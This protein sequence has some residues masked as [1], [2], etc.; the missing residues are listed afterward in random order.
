M[1]YLKSLSNVGHQGMLHRAA[2]FE[3][4]QNRVGVYWCALKNLVS[5]GIR[6]GVQD[7]TTTTCNR[8]LTHTASTHRR[9][10]VRNV[11]RRPLHVDGYI[12]NRRWLAVVESLGNHLAIVRIEHPF[13]TDRMADPERRTAKHL[14]TQCAGMNHRPNVAGGEEIHDVVLA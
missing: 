1:A 5:E 11:Q 12:Q 4:R 9:L 13:L 8:W 7:G 14:A 3:R 6:K 2:S 10:R